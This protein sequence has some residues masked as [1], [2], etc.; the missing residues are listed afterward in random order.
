MHLTG[1]GADLWIKT[2]GSR[3][4]GI[5]QY[6]T[7]SQHDKNSKSTLLSKGVWLREHV[8]FSER[9]NSEVP[10]GHQ[11]AV[12]HFLQ[13][14]AHSIPCLVEKSI[15]WILG[16]CS[17]ISFADLM[18]DFS[19]KKK[20]FGIRNADDLCVQEE[21]ILQLSWMGKVGC[22]NVMEC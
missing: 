18:I 3:T 17:D 1:R 2:K 20:D 15:Y 19:C 6:L 12:L 4:M 9:K 5:Q 7:V 8:V 21:S 22:I 10:F 14:S 11:I 16:S 13:F